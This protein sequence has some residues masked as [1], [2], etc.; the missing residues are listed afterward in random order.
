MTLHSSV[1]H[2]S[3]LIIVNNANPAL[4]S[5]QT[6]PHCPP[7]CLARPCCEEGPLLG[8][9]RGAA[10]WRPVPSWSLGLRWC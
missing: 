8:K 4:K 6:R 2:I 5:S 1:P 10:A 9:A 7:V 3:A